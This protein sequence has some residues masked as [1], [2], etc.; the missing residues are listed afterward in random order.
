MK[1]NQIFTNHMVFQANKP[2]RV[3]GEGRGTVTV[4]FM[5]ETVTKAV[6]TDKWLVEMPS[7][8][9]GGPYEMTVTLNDEMVILNDVYIGEVYLLAG[10]SNIEFSVEGSSYPEEQCENYPL[11]R[12]F[13]QDRLVPSPNIRSEH[14]WMLCEK[15]M[16]K[17]WSAIG[18]HASLKISKEKNIAVGM[19]FC[20]K[21]ASVIESWLP[22]ETALKPEYCIPFEERYLSRSTEKDSPHNEAG[23]LYNATQQKIV[24][25]VFSAVVWYQGESNT[26]SRDYKIYENQLKDLICKWREDF[27]DEK[28]PFLVV[29]IS[30]FDARK[31]D[32]W[33]KIQE[34]QMGIEDKLPDVISVK[35]ADV[36]ESF[37][38]HP[39]TKTALAE[40]I[41]NILQNLARV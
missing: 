24:P 19:V 28:L 15:E 25:Y 14:G 40:R 29:A 6:E 2:I 10:Q 12:A 4:E 26:G 18:Y 27:M 7:H 21:G 3:F 23:A 35:S 17:F 37:D 22:R 41:A 32:A 16:A 13:M 5:G 33:R 38:I 31:D 30:D 36:C 11:V 1:L 20:Y 39:P 34:I 9:Y 8:D